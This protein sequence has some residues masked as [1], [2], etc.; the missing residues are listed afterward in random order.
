MN[1]FNNK[2]EQIAQDSARENDLHL[3]DI[4]F[5]GTNQKP[6]IEVFIDGE[7]DVNAS[8]CANVSNG[9]KKKIDE[10]NLY[11][12]YRLDV[13]SPG[14]DRP[15]IYIWQYPKHVNRTFEIKYKNGDDIEKLIG[16][17]IGVDEDLLTFLDKREIKIK[18]NDI[19]KAKVLVSFNQRR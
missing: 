5:R 13:S 16:K 11:N 12:S 2:I 6:V 17:L 15:L 8:L 9:I 3:V 18:F 14:V 1:S 4:I 19:I 7:E 10:H